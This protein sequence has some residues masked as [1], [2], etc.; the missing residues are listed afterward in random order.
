MS[1]TETSEEPNA[2][3]AEPPAEPAEDPAVT[4]L[5]ATIAKLESEV[6]QKKFSLQ[7]IQDSAEKYTKAGYAREVALVENNKRRRG[8]NMVDNKFAARVGV[9]ET[10][11]PVLDDLDAVGRKYE[12]DEFAKSL[13]ALRAEFMNALQE[14]GVVEYEAKAGDSVDGRRIVA[15]SEEHSEECAKGTVISLVKN[16]FE[17]QGNIV[18]PAECVASLGSEKREE[19]AVS[20]EGE[21]EASSSE[22]G[23]SE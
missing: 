11:L 21:T 8:A 1:D 7:N 12:G 23:A 9:V 15:A 20:K 6:K 18:R 13:G 5:K 10:F 17:I 14:L 19:E 3:A 4:E 16:G 2:E 22:E